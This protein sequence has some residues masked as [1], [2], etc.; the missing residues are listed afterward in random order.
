LEQNQKGIVMKQLRTIGKW[1]S[2]QTKGLGQQ[3]KTSAGI[4]Y[5]E[6]L[7]NPNIWSVVICVG[8]KVTEDIKVGDR[9]MWDISK[10]QGQG[11]GM[12]NIVHQDWIALVER[13]Q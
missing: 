4:I 13:N 8:D 9:V 5:T 7:N 6:K 11:Y 2:V 3:K 12:N 1:V 10:I